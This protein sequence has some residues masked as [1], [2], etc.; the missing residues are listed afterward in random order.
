M[1]RI[2]GI[3]VLILLLAWSYSVSG[4]QM[5]LS[6]KTQ[7][8][9]TAVAAPKTS[10][11]AK[12][13]ER[14]SRPGF[15]LPDTVYSAYT[16]KQ[17]GWY[18]P[19]TI[20]TKEQARHR[21]VS[22]RFTNRNARGKWLKM[23]T[24]SGRGRLV[25]GEVSPYI[26][27]LESSNSRES[28]TKEWIDKLNTTCT[29]EFIPDPTGKEIV[30]ERAYDKEG[31]LVYLYTRTP[32]GANKEGRKQ[33]IGRYNDIYG[34]PAEMRN[35]TTFTYTYG[36][37]VMLTE[38]RWGNDSI[39]EYM[40]A[41]G[42]K[43]PNDDGVA[44]RVSVCDKQGNQ[45]RKEYRDAEGNLAVGKWGYCGLEY[46]RGNG[47]SEF[48]RY[49]VQPTASDNGEINSDDNSIYGNRIEYDQYH[50]MK[51]IQYTDRYGLAV[52]NDGGVSKMAYRYNDYGEIIEQSYHDIDGKFCDYK[53]G[54]AIIKSEYDSVGNKIKTEWLTKDNLPNSNPSIF[55]LSKTETVYDSRGELKS[56]REY[57]AE[58][59]KHKLWY[60]TTISP[61]DVQ[62]YYAKYPDYD[63]D[64]VTVTKTYD[65]RGRL[66]KITYGSRLQT[67]H[68]LTRL[69]AIAKNAV[70]KYK[71]LDGVCVKTSR[72]F[73]TEG[74]PTSGD[75]GDASLVTEIIDS[76]SCLR[77]VWNYSAD[78]N[79]YSSYAIKYSDKDFS[80]RKGEYDVN[81][82]GGIA[83]AGNSSMLRCY[84]AENPKSQ[85]GDVVATVGR[86]EFDEPDYM[87]FAGAPI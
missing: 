63:V 72:Y 85:K 60:E 48:I 29:F 86:D 31:S 14:P 57:K 64:E 46:E 79:L 34:L 78:N 35:D 10:K 36:T 66:V 83:R 70:I 28:A 3:A 69:N 58:N 19:L 40:D 9:K 87:D 55:F 82:F 1:T 32:I 84:F 52:L 26:V 56:Y 24:V 18:S 39:I 76:I 12:E 65:K 51:S 5:R 77:H 53:D 21:S 30:Q 4:Q 47:S 67:P 22:Y 16:A 20:I 41:R 44:L 43:K 61:D 42:V 75:S 73:D 45:L 11:P 71:N 23:E 37:L 6:Q 33:Y 59:G 80:I 2:K 15:L 49:M 27:D 50:R 7:V 38:D 13:A 54:Y 81:I 17:H 25:G 68:N 62:Y 74:L 8:S